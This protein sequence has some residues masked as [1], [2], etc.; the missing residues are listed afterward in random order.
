L[1]NL[2]HLLAE[3]HVNNNCSDHIQRKLYCCYLQNNSHKLNHIKNNLTEKIHEFIKSNSLTEISNID[4]I[5]PAVTVT[6]N[7]DNL[8]IPPSH[9]C[10]RSSDVY[11]INDNTLLRTS[12]TSH[13]HDIANGNNATSYLIY[14]D[15]YRRVEEDAFNSEVHHQVGIQ[16]CTIYMSI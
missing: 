13:L 3:K 7:F 11:Y 10:R 6:Q 16:Y 15:V 4:Y 14:G 12:L 2:K 8:L 9:Y 1:R 5:S